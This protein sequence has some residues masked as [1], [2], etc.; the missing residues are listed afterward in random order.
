MLPLE[1]RQFLSTALIGTNSKVYREA[2]ATSLRGKHVLILPA[3][4]LDGSLY[5]SVYTST[6]STVNPPPPPSFI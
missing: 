5:F 4:V 1:V 6:I 2:R 3:R